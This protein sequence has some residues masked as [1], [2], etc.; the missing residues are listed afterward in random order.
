MDLNTET[1]IWNHCEIF[2]PFLVRSPWNLG[3]QLKFISAA[4]GLTLYSRSMD[5]A[6]NTVLPL[7][8]AIHTENT[9]HM[10]ATQ[11][12]HW[13]AG[14]CL[15]TSYNI[16]PLRHRFHCCACLQSC[17]LAIYWSN[18]LQ[19]YEKL[20][21]QTISKLNKTSLRYTGWDSSIPVFIFNC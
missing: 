21:M 11:L 3:T 7:R 1:G 13:C 2:L 15:A 9:S 5:N 19:Y 6:E 16:R 17:C 18:P 4:S 20:W 12:V 14:C 8:G 10:I